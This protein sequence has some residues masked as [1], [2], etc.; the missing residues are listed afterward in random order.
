[1]ELAELEFWVKQAIKYRQ[2]D[3]EDLEEIC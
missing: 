3:T 2:T 1:M